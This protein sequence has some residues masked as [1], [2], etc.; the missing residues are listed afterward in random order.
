MRSADAEAHKSN[1]EQRNRAGRWNL[2]YKAN[3]RLLGDRDA[4][5]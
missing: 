3:G 1:P 4:D 5:R 2:F